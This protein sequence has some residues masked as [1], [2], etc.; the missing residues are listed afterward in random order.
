MSPTA[1]WAIFGS[2]LFGFAV[3][4]YLFLRDT[5]RLLRGLGLDEEWA[6]SLFVHVAYDGEIIEYPTTWECSAADV[7]DWLGKIEP[8]PEA[9]EA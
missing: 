8:L 2:V 3:I 6:P 7:V 1:E 4:G 5:G 9:V